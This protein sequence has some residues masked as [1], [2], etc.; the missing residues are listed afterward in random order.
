MEMLWKVALGLVVVWLAFVVI[1]LV[2][3]VLFWL[4]VVGVLALGA[5]AAVSWA[6]G[7]KQIR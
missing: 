5:T 1:G 4:A 7:G 2:V 3:K 6:K